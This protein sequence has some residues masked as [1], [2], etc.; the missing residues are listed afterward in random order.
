MGWGGS[1]IHECAHVDAWIGQYKYQGCEAVGV[2]CSLMAFPFWGR[3][4]NIGGS[5]ARA[6]A[7]TSV[8]AQRMRFDGGSVRHGG[9]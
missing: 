1:L 8:G 5:M 2:A 6:R 3:F 4:G 7:R 9:G